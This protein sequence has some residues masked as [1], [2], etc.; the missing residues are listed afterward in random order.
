MKKLTLLTI[1]LSVFGTASAATKP[2]L[3]SLELIGVAA[4]ND[5]NTA[6][7]VCAANN[8]NDPR[9]ESGKYKA[10]TI[11]TKFN[12]KGNFGSIVLIKNDNPALE[13]MNFKNLAEGKEF[14]FPFVK[15]K[16]ANKSGKPAE[17]FEIIKSGC[18][19]SI[20]PSYKNGSG[21]AV[22]EKLGFDYHSNSGLAV[23]LKNPNGGQNEKATH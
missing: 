7:Q 16:L 8:I 2:K 3:D 23:L 13:K 21:G 18:F 4:F 14:Q 12:A 1:L 20:D 19:W 9:C 17:L 6:Q 22:C 15:V 5:Q 10:V 11:G